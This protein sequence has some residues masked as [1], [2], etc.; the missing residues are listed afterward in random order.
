M[1]AV[2]F[3]QRCA[4]T[5]QA[6]YQEIE[7]PPYEL[8]PLVSAA[9][10]AFHATPPHCPHEICL[11]F[12]DNYPEKPKGSNILIVKCLKCGTSQQTLAPIELVSAIVICFHASHEAHPLEFTYG[13]RTVRSP[14][15]NT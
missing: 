15:A 2:I 10:V 13:G 9:L 12:E 1:K 7:A 6:A 3:C 4:G 14:E 5:P 8:G 11:S